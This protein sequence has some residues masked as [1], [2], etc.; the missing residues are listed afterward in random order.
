MDKIPYIML[1]MT[2]KYGIIIY[3]DIGK[4]DRYGIYT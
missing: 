3:T 2:K 4:G 1:N